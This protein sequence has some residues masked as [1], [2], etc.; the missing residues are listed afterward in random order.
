MTAHV[1]VAFCEYEPLTVVYTQS[2]RGVESGSRVRPKGHLANT[3]TRLFIFKCVQPYDKR[4]LTIIL[5]YRRAKHCLPDACLVSL[6]GTA[7]HALETNLIAEASNIFTKGMLHKA[8][9]RPLLHSVAVVALFNLWV[10]PYSNAFFTHSP[11]PVAA[12]RQTRLKGIPKFRPSGGVDNPI[13]TAVDV[14]VVGSCNM[15]LVAYTCR[16]PAKG[17]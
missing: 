15:D 10:L 14:V 17:Q 7:R 4:D 16:L 6:S 13:M 3:R 11:R 2:C 12:N 8:P 9:R 1:H 5:I